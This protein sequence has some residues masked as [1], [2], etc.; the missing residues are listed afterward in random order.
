MEEA[1][2]EIGMVVEGI[3]TTKSTYE[4]AGDIGVEMPIT[5][6]LYNVL[7]NGAN[8]RESVGKLMG[9]AMKHEMEIVAK[10]KKTSW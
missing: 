8:V 9:R 6:E 7:Y 2:E 3:K 4:L 10:N 5:K 1:A